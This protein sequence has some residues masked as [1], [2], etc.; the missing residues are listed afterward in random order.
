MYI[1]YYVR[2]S[3]ILF[4]KCYLEISRGKV[5]A[6]LHWVSFSKHWNNAI[7]CFY[8]Q[9]FSWSICNYFLLLCD[10]CSKLFHFPR[11][12]SFPNINVFRFISIITGN[13]SRFI[14][15]LQWLY[16]IPFRFTCFTSAPRDNTYVTYVEGSYFLVYVFQY[17]AFQ[18]VATCRQVFKENV[19]P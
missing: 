8:C 12:L 6:I 19:V 15:L 3:F 17:Y 9:G 13:A 1:C 10:S 11:R 5:Q 14:C 16:H 18:C 7:G 2:V 4:F